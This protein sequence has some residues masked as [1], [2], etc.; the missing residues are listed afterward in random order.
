MLDRLRTPFF[1]IALIAVVIAVLVEL[2]SSAVIPEPP[3]DPGVIT[4]SIPSELQGD[5]GAVNQLVSDSR[6]ASKPPGIAIRDMALLDGL[7]VFTALLIGLP[8]LFPQSLFGRVQGVATLIVSVLI[9][10]GGIG[11]AL[12]AFVKLMIM[13]SLFTAAPFGTLAYLAMWGFF[14]RGGATVALSLIM[15]F[16][17]AFAVMLIAAQQRFL[18]NKG[19]V[20]IIVTSLLAN[21]IISFLHVLVP[22]ILVSITDAIAAIVVLILAIIWGIFLFI[23]SIPAIV[24][25]VV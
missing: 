5:A 12:A 6:S 8:L 16:K 24:K 7:L 17:V 20:L 22:G 15:L 3:F 1:V 23:A 10:L 13:V 4:S 25:A 2:G 21:I 18:Q 14:N 9:I 11:L 19:L